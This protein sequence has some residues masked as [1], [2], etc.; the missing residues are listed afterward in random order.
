[1]VNVEFP[2][3]V[4]LLAFH[5][6]HVNHRHPRI[7]TGCLNLAPRLISCVKISDVLV[8]SEAVL[9]L[10]LD[11]QIPSTNILPVNR[12]SEYHDRLS[13]IKSWQEDGGQKNKSL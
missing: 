8:L 4:K 9:L 3:N 12:A 11:S 5:A 13:G 6:E 7:S 10:V 2:R 1:M